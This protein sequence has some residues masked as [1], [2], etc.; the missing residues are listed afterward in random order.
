MSG[1]PK[2]YI[3]LDTI[4]P[5][6]NNQ[7]IEVTLGESYYVILFDNKPCNI[8]LTNRDPRLWMNTKRYHKTGYINKAHAQRRVDQLNKLFNTKL[9]SIKEII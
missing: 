1:R 3:V 7:L 4:N 8:I 2:P 9:F 5:K 6:N